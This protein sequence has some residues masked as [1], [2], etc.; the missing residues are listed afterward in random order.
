MVEPNAPTSPPRVAD[1][2]KAM[3]VPPVTR[4]KP[5][6]TAP[7][8]NIDTNPNQSLDINRAIPNSTN[9]NDHISQV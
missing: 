5:K 9:P 8:A 7:A 3:G 4:A 2:K 1:M 6:T